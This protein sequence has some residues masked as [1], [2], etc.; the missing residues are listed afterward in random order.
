M[1]AVDADSR[2]SDL[3]T[4]PLDP[5]DIVLVRYGE[6]SLK[7]GNRR[8]FEQT[9]VRN[10]RAALKSISPVKIERSHGRLAVFPERR[11]LAVAKRLTEVF[12]I[13]SVSPAWS[14]TSEPEKILDL[15]R[16]VFADAERELGS[17]AKPSVRVQTKRANKRFPIRSRD[18]DVFIAERTFVDDRHVVRLKAADITLGIDIRDERT[19]VFARR[20]QG[21]GGLPVS[22]LGR[23]LCLLSGGIDSPVAAWMTMKRGSRVDFVTFH[24]FPYIGEPSKK[25]VVDLVRVLTRYQPRSRLSVVPFTAS[26]EAIRDFAPEPYRTV[27]YRRMMQRIASRLARRGKAGALVT[28]ECLGQVASQTLE[29]LGCIGAASSLQVL[30]PL[31]GFDKEETIRIA[32]QIGT[33]E[34]SI[35]PEP[36]CCTVF[37]PSKPVLRG[38]LEECLEAESGFDVDRLVLDAVRGTERIDVE[39]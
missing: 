14:T 18:F 31:I 22:T 30:R 21:P 32:R 17:S 27:L 29:N 1:S 6:L 10:M 37:Q 39:L 2:A 8:E 28:G 12:G 38:R 19:Y 3:E 5:P 33:F 26:Q 25:K 34:L 7:G 23:T 15:A 36:D 35:L 11:A 13:S 20:L 16:L 9:L 4:E 24:S